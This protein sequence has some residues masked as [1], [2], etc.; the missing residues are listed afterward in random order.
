MATILVV[1]DEVAVRFVV[2]AALNEA[3]WRVVEAWSGHAAVKILDNPGHV[4]L[5][6]TDLNLAGVIDGLAVARI[7][8]FGR[9]HVKVVFLSADAANDSLRGW[10]DGF[11]FKPCDLSALVQTVT[12]VLAAA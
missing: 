8:R 1:E 5:V 12:N 10:G 2:V 9:P 3:G 7:A 6:L 11:L 4:D